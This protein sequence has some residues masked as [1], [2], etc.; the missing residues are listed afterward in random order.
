M[1]VNVATYSRQSVKLDQGIERQLERNR[2]E[3]KRRGWTVVEEYVDN[4]TSAS[5]VRG[6]KTAWARMLK[7]AEAGRFT[8]VLAV[9]IDRLIRSQRDML[10]LLG[11][12]LKV[13]TVDGEIDL[14]TADGGFRASML[15][16]IARFETQRKSERQRRANESRVSK[17]Q[18]VPGRRRFGYEPDGM[19][20]R[21]SEAAQVRWAFE[22]I[23]S[24][25]SLR[26][27]AL[28]LGW[29]PERVRA[30]LNNETYS[31]MVRHKGVYLPSTQVT[32]IVSAKLQAEVRAILADPTRRTSPGSAVKHLMSGIARCGVSGC[33]SPLF[34]M[35]S[36]IC[37][38]DTSH[39][40]IL[41]KTLDDAV[42]WEVFFWIVGHPDAE[43]SADSLRLR[44]L[45][46]ESAEANRQRAIQQEM[47]TW[48][49][50]DLASIRRTVAELG[51]TI[52]ALDIQIETERGSLARSG[53][54]EAVRGEWWENRNLRQY[55]EQE[56]AVL[57]A[58]P[59]YW[60]GLGLDRQREII[61][62]TMEVTVL[63]GRS[64]ERVVCEWL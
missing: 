39:V 57:D 36:Y 15:A 13:T 24:G 60:D 47:A 53:V 51:K 7:D 27:V 19:T 5:K 45:L 62:S 20:P 52:E 59:A 29:R 44:T 49:G 14:S 31:G 21:E 50:A 58:W 23:R 63:K 3:A 18:P 32:P 33:G 54:V 34:F 9:D 8:H 2:V 4:D 48:D 42:M 1:S 26:S 41:K 22:Q 16:S 12:G 46:A 38:A 28:T 30:T 55:S 56:Q 37:K 17:G 11:L 35:R 40:S 43:D 25:A 61:R 6:P 64:P 10:T